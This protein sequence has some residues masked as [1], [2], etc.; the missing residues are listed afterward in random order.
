MELIEREEH[1]R[2]STFPILDDDMW[3]IWENSPARRQIISKMEPF[4]YVPEKVSI[5]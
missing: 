3:K 1:A 4:M 5:P 2:Y